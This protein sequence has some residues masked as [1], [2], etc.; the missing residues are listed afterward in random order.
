MTCIGQ[1]KVGVQRVPPVKTQGSLA[2]INGPTAKG[3]H[4][5]Y[6]N[7]FIRGLHITHDTEHAFRKAW[8]CEALLALKK[9]DLN[10]K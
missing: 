2:C 7:T 5:R 10:T 4:L 8:L 6:I 1:I 9:G 3:K